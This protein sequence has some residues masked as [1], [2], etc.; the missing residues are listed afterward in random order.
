MPRRVYFVQSSHWDR[1]WFMTF[2]DY[3][4]RLVGIMDR[5]LDRI[6]GGKMAGP[7]TA[8]GQTVLLEDYLEIRSYRRNELQEALRRG[9]IV[10]G[11]WYVLPDQFLISGESLVRNLRLGRERARLL[12]GRPSNAGF[13]GDLFGHISQLPQ[14]FQQFGIGCVY[15]WRGT[16][17]TDTR[18]FVWEGSDGTELLAYRFGPFGYGDFAHSVRHADVGTHMYSEDQARG[19]FLDFLN[20]EARYTSVDP[21]LIFDGWDHLEPEYIFHERLKTWVDPEKYDIIFGSFDDYQKEV[22]QDL[23][24]VNHRLVG[25][26]REPGS[27]PN[28]IDTQWLIPG[29]LSSRINLKLENYECETLLTQWAEPFHCVASSLIPTDHLEEFINHAWEYLLKNHPHDSLCG[30]SIDAVHRDMEYRFSQCRQIGERLTMESLDAI[31]RHIDSDLPDGGLRV[32]VY[33][34]LPYDRTGVVELSL[35]LPTDWP[36][37][38]EFYRFEAKSGFRIFD[39][40]GNDI[41]YQRMRQRTSRQRFRSRPTRLAEGYRTFGV[42]VAVDMNVPAF[43]YR[44]LSIKPEQLDTPTRHPSGTG[45]IAQAHNR[46]ENEYIRVDIQGNGTISLL[47]KQTG[48]RY[49][50]LLCLEDGADIGDGWYHGMAQNDEVYYSSSCHA[51]LSIIQD[52]PNLATIRIRCRMLIPESFDFRELVRSENCVPYFVENYLTLRKGEPFLAIRTVVKNTVADHRLRM[53]FPSDLY[54]DHFWTDSVYDTVRRNVALREDNHL[55]RELEVET[56]PQ[57][58]W[59]AA[60]DG[61]NGLAVVSSGILESTVQDLE[62][63]PIALTLLRSTRKTVYTDGEPDGLLLDTN[64][65]FKTRLVPFQG[66]PDFQRLTLYGH[67]LAAGMRMVSISQADLDAIPPRN[68]IRLPQQ[69]SFLKIDG[70]I[71]LTSYR[72]VC[73]TIELRFYNP[74]FKET[75]GLIDFSVRPEGIPLPETLHIVNLESKRNGGK[76]VGSNGQFRIPVGPKKIVTLSF[77]MEESAL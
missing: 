22:L 69:A 62:R 26:L 25:E 30:C 43:G 74:T 14:V 44:T 53:L 20:K 63:R 12:G 9:E 28:E 5:L 8:D 76:I 7:F 6:S 40:S 60:S 58:S 48:R 11:P 15:L 33:N 57:R 70:A 66:E 18:H 75:T 52:G 50:D 68:D 56:K 46:L 49:T 42:Q 41:P 55:L 39:E 72:V 71:I 73:G 16:N 37:F 31:A 61:T 38:E 47:H 21:I 29:V 59:I 1:E 4:Y 65:E 3:R 32:V 13:V 23:G 35:E 67:E 17:L 54:T 27:N 19:D 24:R 64:L 45:S 51:D 10:A 2:Q 36:Y 77:D 34:P